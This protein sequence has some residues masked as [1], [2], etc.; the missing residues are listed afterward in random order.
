M[1]SLVSRCFRLSNT[2]ANTN[3]H[4]SQIL[5]VTKTD[6]LVTDRAGTIAVW[7]SRN[8]F[9]SAIN[10]LRVEY[11]IHTRCGGTNDGY[12]VNGF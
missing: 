2:E 3:S 11:A 12:I 5:L 6:W 9:A 10:F 7:A 1:L 8:L 4:L